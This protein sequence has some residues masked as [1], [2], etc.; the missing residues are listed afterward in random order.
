[1]VAFFFLIQRTLGQSDTTITESPSEHDSP[2]SAALSKQRAVVTPALL[3]AV[4]SL[5]HNL[6]VVMPKD[7]GIALQQTHLLTTLSRYEINNC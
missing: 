5:L 6:L 2:T 4:C 7:T 1:M 3:S